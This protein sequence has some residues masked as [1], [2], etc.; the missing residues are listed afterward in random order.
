MI[1][2]DLVFWF[3]GSGLFN[4]MCMCSHMCLCVSVHTG[5]KRTSD[6]LKLKL[7]IVVSQHLTWVLLGTKL[8]SSRRVGGTLLPLQSLWFLFFKDLTS[9]VVRNHVQDSHIFPLE[10]LEQRMQIKVSVLDHFHLFYTI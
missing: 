3:Y 9:K 7:Q 2:A 8:W 10:P 4:W 6:P 1:Q 5:Q